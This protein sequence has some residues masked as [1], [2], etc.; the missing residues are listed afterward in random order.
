MPQAKTKDKAKNKKGL[1]VLLLVLIGFLVISLGLLNNFKNSIATPEKAFI[2]LKDSQAFNN[3]SDLTKAQIRQNYPEDVKNNFLK[4]ALVEKTMDLIVTPQNI[5]N[6]SQPAIKTLYR[7]TARANKLSRETIIVNTASFKDQA[8]SYLPTLGLPDQFESATSD[9]IKSVPDKVVI[10]DPNSQKNTVF[11][12]LVSIS[13]AYRTVNTLSDIA[14]AGLLISFVLLILLY[15]KNLKSIFKPISI[16]LF[17]SAVITGLISYF[18]PSLISLFIPSVQSPE[19]A[20]ASNNLI[21]GILKNFFGNYSS[22][23]WLLVF[24]SVL[25]YAIHLLINN[26]TIKSKLKK[27][28]IKIKPNKNTTKKS[29]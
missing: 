19:I 16:T 24:M 5:E 1:K 9:F 11:S 8:N 21:M 18:A 27:V 12:V 29:K 14:L 17:V 7:A 6:V 10:L 25:T 20:S 23:F 3:I 28:Y 15:V 13:K 26:A 4:K 2:F 22:Y